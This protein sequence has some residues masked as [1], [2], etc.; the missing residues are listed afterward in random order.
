[1]L[2]LASNISGMQINLQCGCIAE[3][4]TKLITILAA[5]TTPLNLRFS[6]KGVCSQ[7]AYDFEGTMRK[8]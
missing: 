6:E 4:H 5:S 1:M 3:D 8:K 2:Y 7:E